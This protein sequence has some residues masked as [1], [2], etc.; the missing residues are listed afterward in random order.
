MTP[1]FSLICASHLSPYP[2]G[3]TNRLA[4]FH[5]AVKSVVNQQFK[6]WELIIIGDGCNLTK[7]AV[8]DYA[9]IDCIK[10]ILVDKQPHL[11]GA[12]RNAGIAKATGQYIGYI[13]TDDALGAEHL[14][15]LAEQVN[16]EPWYFFNDWTA[17]IL[18]ETGFFERH[19]SPVIKGSC[20]TSNIIHRRNIPVKWE[21][22]YEHDWLLIQQLRKY[23][24]PVFLKT[25]KYYCC[26]IPKQIDL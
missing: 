23:C 15:I 26:H 13:D 3:A 25:P 7:S 1:L 6:D 21:D 24:E 11:S 10:T 22:G 8:E 19:C 14:S 17:R 2:G 18:P 12:V 9:S 16:G 20:G 5:R 4:K